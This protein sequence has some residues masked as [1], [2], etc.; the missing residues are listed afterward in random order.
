VDDPTF[1]IR[2]I[3]IEYR[4]SVKGPP[5]RMM[6]YDGDALGV[7]LSRLLIAGATPAH[8]RPIHMEIVRRLALS[9]FRHA[10]GQPIVA[11]DVLTLTVVAEDFDDVT[12][13]KSPGRSHEIDLRVVRP[14]QLETK[15]QAA[16]GDPVRAKAGSLAPPKY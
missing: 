7:A 15:A 3:A 6:L 1:A 12:P 13:D 4:T 8:V 11:G 5:R 14:T 9:A 10:D 2:R 16:R